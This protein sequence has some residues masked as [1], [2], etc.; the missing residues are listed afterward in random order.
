[1]S[2]TSVGVLD[3]TEGEIVVVA[4]G[5]IEEARS[6]VVDVGAGEMGTLV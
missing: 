1:M 3:R 5:A 2:L 4:A 6:H